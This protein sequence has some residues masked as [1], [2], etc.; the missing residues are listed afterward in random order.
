MSYSREVWLYIDAYNFYYSVIHSPNVPVEAL[1]CD[2][3]QLAETVLL[4][5][6]EMLKVRK[7]FA[8]PKQDIAKTDMERQQQQ[9]WLSAISAPDKVISVSNGLCD[10]LVCGGYD[11]AILISG[12]YKLLA[13]VERVREISG[14]NV[15][16]WLP[17][18]PPYKE[19]RKYCGGRGILNNRLTLE[20]IAY[21]P[22]PE[23]VVTN[24]DKI[25]RLRDCC[26]LTAR[27]SRKAR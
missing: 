16:I 22:L 17:P 9:R 11:K 13:A 24:D 4:A 2:F 6:D 27:H 19:F 23:K 26:D 18:G 25:I 20:M 1:W 7:F 3:T 14:K 10:D 8:E 21:N 12:D 5:D 15:E